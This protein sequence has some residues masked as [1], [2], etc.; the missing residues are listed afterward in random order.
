MPHPHALSR[1]TSSVGRITAAGG[2][3]SRG[4]QQR[5]DHL[6]AD[7]PQRMADRRQCRALR[8][9]PWNRRTRRR[10]RPPV[11]VVRPGAGPP[12]RRAPSRPI[13]RTP[14]QGRERAAARRACPAVPPRSRSANAPGCAATTSSRVSRPGH[15][16][17]RTR[18]RTRARAAHRRRL[19]DARHAQQI[20]QRI[21]GVRGHQQRPVD[22][23]RGEEP[24]HPGAFVS[25]RRDAQEQPDIV[26][27]RAWWL[28]RTRCAG[29]PGS[30]PPGPTAKRSAR[31]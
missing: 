23:S 29:L 27:D 14:R 7:P 20:Q 10:R 30:P 19:R 18:P 28:T 31:R 5:A 2:S 26:L 24:R 17:P 6:A 13:R 3:P 21:P 4:G 22:V 11:P 25:R 1:R 8:P 12:G 16:P 15:P 9:R